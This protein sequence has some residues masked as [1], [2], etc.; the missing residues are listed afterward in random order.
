MLAMGQTLPLSKSLAPLV[1]LTAIFALG[2][3]ILAA[4]G[5]D[6]PGTTELLWTFEFRLI[7]TWWVYADSSARG[8]SA[9]FEFEALV[10][11]AWPFVV[12]Y[13]LCRSRGP[14]G[15][16]FGVGI[17]GLYAAPNVIASVIHVTLKK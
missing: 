8:F 12:P 15:L 17:W 7:L 3:S 1:V 5:V 14:R 11:W 4:H 6:V 9:P 2:L 16:L 10:F 13:Y